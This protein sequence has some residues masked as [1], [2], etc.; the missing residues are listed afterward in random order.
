MT[1]LVADLVAAEHPFGDL[2]DAAFERL[3]AE[4]ADLVLWAGDA[5]VIP[6]S[7]LAQII[8]GY[9]ALPSRDDPD[10]PARWLPLQ[11]FLRGLLHS[12]PAS[13]LADL[14]DLLAD[15][16]LRRALTLID[17]PYTYLHAQLTDGWVKLRA[18]GTVEQVGGL[19]G[20][21]TSAYVDRLRECMPAIAAEEQAL[22]ISH[23][24]HG[25]AVPDEQG[26]FYV[27][28]VRVALTQ[29]EPIA[30]ESWHVM[31]R[32]SDQAVVTFTNATLAQ[33]RCALMNHHPR[34]G[35]AY[36]Q[37]AILETKLK[38]EVAVNPNEPI[39]RRA[40]DR[41]G[42]ITSELREI[43]QDLDGRDGKI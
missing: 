11:A 26:R 2:H 4:L 23:A 39:L 24:Y 25:G 16:P 29:P 14:S 13:T 32:F 21:I 38:I 42:A 28:H 5:Q 19:H 9:A 17:D 1:V 15:K 41:V 35:A 8:A 34:A 3:E 12:L 36:A 7:G 43:L 40:R 31:D 6:A 27:R 37:A 18:L 30:T 33:G 20:F 22:R 10:D